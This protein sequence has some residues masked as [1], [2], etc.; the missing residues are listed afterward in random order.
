MSLRGLVALGVG[1]FIVLLAV[2][3]PAQIV[4]GQLARAGVVL[5]GVSGSLWQGRAA[6]LQA[7]GIRL[8]ELTWDLHVLKLLTARAAANI[9]LRQND[10]FATGEVVALPTGRVELTDFSASWP[11][12]QLSGGGIPSGWTGMLTLRLDELALDNGVPAAITGTIDILQLVGPANR[13]AA[14]G[15]YRVIFPAPE[16]S[17]GEGQV[18]GTLQDSEGPIAVNGTVRLGPGRS[19]ELGGLI[20][21]RPGAPADVVNALQ[22]LGEPD[23]E[24]RR[25]FSIAGTY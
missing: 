13:P 21:T 18:V 25:P 14:L 9:S 6:S 10:A 8:G 22:Y 7:G 5:G 15:S 4:T 11:L 1:A 2:T 20:A 16:V 3:F 17:P 12:A 19:Y 23:G 24:G